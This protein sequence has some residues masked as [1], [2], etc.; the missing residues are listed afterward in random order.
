MIHAWSEVTVTHRHPDVGVSE[1]LLYDF[2]MCSLHHQ[3]TGETVTDVVQANGTKSGLLYDAPEGVFH[4]VAIQVLALA[5][6]EHELAAFPRKRPKSV[7]ECIT[8]G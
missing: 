4:L 3:L 8:H 2:Q 7:D 1:Q 6:W 5:V